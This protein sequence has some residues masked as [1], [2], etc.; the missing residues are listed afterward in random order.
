MK[1]LN[2]APSHLIPEGRVRSIYSWQLISWVFFVCQAPKVF[3]FDMCYFRNKIGPR[4]QKCGF[5]SF[6]KLVWK[7]RSVS[8]RVLQK[9]VPSLFSQHWYGD[10]VTD[11][12]KWLTPKWQRG[13][14]ESNR[15][16][17]VTNRAVATVCHRATISSRVLSLSQIPAFRAL[18]TAG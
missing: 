3:T 11:I 7:V 4:C 10:W 13:V 2:I 18:L 12:C 14:S 5:K 1:Y 16:K 8:V 6:F 17:L 9:A 15:V